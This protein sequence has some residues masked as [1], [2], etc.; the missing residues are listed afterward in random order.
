MTSASEYNVILAL[1]V[2]LGVSFLNVFLAVLL[3]RINTSF[4]SC[5]AVVNQSCLSVSSVCI[6]RS[7]PEQFAE[8]SSSLSSI[9]NVLVLPT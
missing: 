1:T 7:F 2:V 6:D 4:Y 5:E 9:Y 3:L 8:E